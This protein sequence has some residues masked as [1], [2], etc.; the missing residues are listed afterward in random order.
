[1]FSTLNYYNTDTFNL[2]KKKKKWNDSRVMTVMKGITKVL[3]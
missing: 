3:L 1:M 2:D